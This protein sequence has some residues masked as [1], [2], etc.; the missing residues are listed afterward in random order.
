MR[1]RLLAAF[2]LL[3]LP[4]LGACNDPTDVPDALIDEVCALGGIANVAGD[5]EAQARL[6]EGVDQCHRVLNLMRDADPA[7]T[8]AF[9]HCTVQERGKATKTTIEL[10]VFGCIPM[11]LRPRA[12]KTLEEATATVAWIDDQ[13]AA[14]AK[15][16][17]RALKA[18]GEAS[19]AGE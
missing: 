14:A 3:C 8:H 6:D 7:A 1:I 17:D 9:A 10:A 19:P 16:E 12:Q 2:A 5:P 15:E 13:E 4:L 18:Q 11:H